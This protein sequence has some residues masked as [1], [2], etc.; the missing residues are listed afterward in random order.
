MPVVEMESGG[1]QTRPTELL[2]ALGQVKL[3]ERELERRG[4]KVPAV[5]EYRGLLA[6]SEDE[7]LCQLCVSAPAGGRLACCG[8]SGACN[9]CLR[10]LM[11]R[12][13][14]CPHCRAASCEL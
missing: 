14:R 8:Y 13:D 4:L 2:W 10:I 11:D 5:G 12:G 6:V 1:V 3:L 7:D 9:G